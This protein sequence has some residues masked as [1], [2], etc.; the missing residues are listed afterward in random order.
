M[1]P[2][3]SAWLAGALGLCLL[4]ANVA[5][6][7]DLERSVVRRASEGQRRSR[8]WRGRV[9]PAFALPLLD[10]STHRVAAE[11]GG[12]VHV[13]VFFTTWCEE[14][15]TDLKEIQQHAE[16]LQ[17]A[18]QR[19]QVVGI[20]VQEEPQAVSRFAK[21]HGIVVPV[22]ADLTGTVMRAYEV[23]TF[24][25]VVVIG[26]D[27]RTRLYHEG[28]VVNADVVLDPVVITTPRSATP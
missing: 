21:T 22:G 10:G 1:T 5:I 11:A 14:C 16:R 25:T 2:S 18:G 27:G 17:A 4:G 20:A 12:Q 26:A 8:E 19:V 13:L 15:P 28:P 24:P 23:R 3:G 7:P 9:A 6:K